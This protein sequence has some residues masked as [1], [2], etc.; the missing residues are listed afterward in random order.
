MKLTTAIA[1]NI[2]KVYLNIGQATIIGSFLTGFLGKE[3][4]FLI[5][6][7]TFIIGGGTVAVGLWFIGKA[8]QQA[9]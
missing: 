1:E 6:T 8:E 5:S 7:L 3:W 4:D 2:G 9:R